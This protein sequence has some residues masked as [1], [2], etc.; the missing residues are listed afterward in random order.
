[1]RKLV[2]ASILASRQPNTR[3]SFENKKKLVWTGFVPRTLCVLVGHSTTELKK[4]KTSF[5]KNLSLYRQWEIFPLPF[6]PFPT[7]GIR[8]FFLCSL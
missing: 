1:M 6:P 8:K 5:A 2:L 7:E 3:E 4:L